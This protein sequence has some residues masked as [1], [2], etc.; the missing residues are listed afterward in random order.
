MPST[1]ERKLLDIPT[2]KKKERNHPQMTQWIELVTTA[3]TLRT[4]TA[5]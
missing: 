5:R 4:E 1:E 3:I 2:Y